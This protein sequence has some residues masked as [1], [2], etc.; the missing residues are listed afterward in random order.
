MVVAA[1]ERPLTAAR[2]LGRSLSLLVRLAGQRGKAK[3]GLKPGAGSSHSLESLAQLGERRDEHEERRR[4]LEKFLALSGR[5][6]AGGHSP[7]PIGGNQCFVPNKNNR[8]NSSQARVATS[9]KQQATQPPSS[10][11]NLLARRQAGRDKKRPLAGGAATSGKREAAASLRWKPT[12]Q[13]QPSGADPKRPSGA[14]GFW[15]LR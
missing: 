14:K 6:L 15:H 4:R 13:S 8:I 3:G 2:Q 7:R 10:C 12:K 5:R 9:G 1:D 11:T